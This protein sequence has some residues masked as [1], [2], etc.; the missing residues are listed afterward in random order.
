MSFH[1]IQFL[2][3]HYNSFHSFIDSFIRSSFFFHVHVHFFAFHFISLSFQFMQVSCFFDA[4]FLPF[5]DQCFEWTIALPSARLGPCIFT[6]WFMFVFSWSPEIYLL[7]DSVFFWSLAPLPRFQEGPGPSTLEGEDDGWVVHGWLVKQMWGKSKEQ[8]RRP[9]SLAYVTNKNVLRQ[10]FD[11]FRFLIQSSFP[12]SVMEE[13]RRFL[14]W[15]VLNGQDVWSMICLR[16]YSVM[17]NVF[18]CKEGFKGTHRS[19]SQLAFWICQWWNIKPQRSLG[20]SNTMQQKSGPRGWE[21]YKLK[22]GIQHYGNTVGAEEWKATISEDVRTHSR[23][24]LGLVDF[25]E[26][27]LGCETEWKWETEQLGHSCSFWPSGARL[28]CLGSGRCDGMY[29]ASC[30]GGLHMLQ[31][32]GF[33][34]SCTVSSLNMSDCSQPILQTTTC[35]ATSE[36]RIMNLQISGF[37]LT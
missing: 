1:F 33:A 3:F 16:S 27:I 22:G 26:P 32:G 28:P 8:S 34:F 24:C 19:A 21:V 23:V 35:S 7:F 13:F 31:F 17:I 18:F 10:I 4:F 36:Q 6:C 14:K 11:L 20:R 37:Y 25:L 5:L 15:T 29:R 2:S 12:F 30:L 9:E